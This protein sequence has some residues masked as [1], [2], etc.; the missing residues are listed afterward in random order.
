MIR[1]AFSFTTKE[2]VMTYTHLSEKER[3]HIELELKKGISKKEIAESLG[4]YPS[5]ITREIKRN[6]GKRGYRH[7]QAGRQVIQR[8]KDKPKAIKLTDEVIV[9]ITTLL[10]Q[11]CG[12][13]KLHKSI[14]LHHETICRFIYED[15]KAG[16]E[17][18]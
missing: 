4:R 17:L 8:H 9:D 18:Y 12:Y 6:T 15:K 13:L 2:I 14:L 11:I 7:K 10:K 5:L 16:G 1:L 3:Y